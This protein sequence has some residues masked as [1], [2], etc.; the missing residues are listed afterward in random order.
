[1]RVDSHLHFWKFEPVKDAWITDE[2]RVIKENFYPKDL[3][4]HMEMAGI[5]IGIAVQADQS[6]Q[7]ND[8][9]LAQATQHDFIKGIVGWVDFRAANINER[10]AYYARNPL[11]KGFRHIVQAEPEDDFLLGKNFCHGI[12]LLEKYGFTYDILIYPKHISY[13]LEFAR[14]FPNIKMVLNHIAKPNIKK[15]EFDHW[16]RLIKQF[17]DL[18]NVSC[19]IAGLVTEADWAFW[20][21][22]D[23]KKYIDLTLETF[24]INRIMFG[25]DWPVCLVGASYL[26]VCNILKENTMQLSKEEQQ[27]LWGGNCIDFYGLKY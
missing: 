23:F 1:M 20:K 14:R 2:M 26:E 8:F 12:A 7:E 15:Q 16:S 19:K 3:I 25:S 22:D 21:Y 6:E 9:L 17:S 10:L 4:P 24:G 27:K 13:A 11:M 18:Q 5:N